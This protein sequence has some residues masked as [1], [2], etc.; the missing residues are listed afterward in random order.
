MAEGKVQ[1]ELD[2]ATC[3]EEVL[4]LLQLMAVVQQ[5]SVRKI[6]KKMTE[7]PPKHQGPQQREWNKPKMLE[8]CSATKAISESMYED[9]ECVVTSSNFPFKAIFKVQSLSHVDELLA[10]TANSMSRWCFVLPGSKI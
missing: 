6:F 8:V 2:G 4:L 5:N 7:R 9:C 3:N 10:T 1:R